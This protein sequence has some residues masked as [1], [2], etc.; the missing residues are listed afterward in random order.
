ME[1][2]HGGKREGAGRPNV[3]Q[4]PKKVLLTLEQDHIA[5][6]DKV[7]KDLSTPEHQYSRSEVMRKLISDH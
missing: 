1:N 3:L 4:N 2:T 6:L 5:K 7:K